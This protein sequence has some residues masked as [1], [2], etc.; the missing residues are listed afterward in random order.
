MTPEEPLL[1]PGVQAAAVL[2]LSALLIWIIHLVRAQRLSLRDSLLWIL[3]TGAALALMAF[4]ATL[5]AAAGLLGV[6]VPANGLF[7]VALL[8]VAVN[9]LSCTLAVSRNAERTRRLAQECALLRAE[10]DS[11]RTERDGGGGT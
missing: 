11:L 10:L 1:S 9:V 6:R 8:Y 3:S 5:Q 2:G 4:P 7:A